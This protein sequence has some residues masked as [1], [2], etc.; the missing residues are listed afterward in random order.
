MRRPSVILAGM[1]RSGKR[2]V[3]LEI[4][5]SLIGAVVLGVGLYFYIDSSIEKPQPIALAPQTIER[6]ES[7][8]VL[9]DTLVKTF[10]QR[11]HAQ[12]FVGVVE[13]MASPIR[14]RTS[15]EQMRTWIAADPYLSLLRTITILRTTEQRL[16]DGPPHTPG[17]STLRATGV[18]KLDNGSAVEITLHLVYEEQAFKIASVLVAGI[19]ALPGAHK[20]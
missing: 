7:H 10:A 19:P 11:L 6:G 2:N 13:L 14:A 20:E 8:A 12:D 4:A 5:L 1:A 16:N 17:A 9:V 3:G 18:M 15:A